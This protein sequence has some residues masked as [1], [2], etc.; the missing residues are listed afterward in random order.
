[1]LKYRLKIV[2]R[3]AKIT[4]LCANLDNMLKQASH[5]RPNN[6]LLPQQSYDGCFRFNSFAITVFN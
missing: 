6:N 2:A 4:Y 3:L 1:M 5:N